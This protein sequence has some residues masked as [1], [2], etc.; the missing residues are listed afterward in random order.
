MEREELAAQSCTPCRGGVEPLSRAAAEGLLGQTPEWSLQDGACK[1]VR[2]WTF[3]GFARAF[4]FVEKVAALAEAER[5]HPDIRFGWGYV[6]IELMTHAIG[7]LHRNDF[8]L[9]AKIDRIEVSG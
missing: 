1:I 6:E 9:A 5:H 3:K 8:V 4:A 7:G 2:R